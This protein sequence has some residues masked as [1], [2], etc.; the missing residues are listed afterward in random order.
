MGAEVHSCS[1]SYVATTAL[2]DILWKVFKV[3]QALFTF[4]RFSSDK[5]GLTVDEI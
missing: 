2:R 1:P 5:R 3:L 4:W